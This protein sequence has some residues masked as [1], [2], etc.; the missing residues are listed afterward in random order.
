MSHLQNVP[1]HSIRKR[2]N[3]GGIVASTVYCNLSYALSPQIGCH[4]QGLE[5]LCCFFCHSTA[6]WCSHPNS[7]V[8]THVE[9]IC[10]VHACKDAYIHLDILHVYSVQENYRKRFQ[11]I[12]GILSKVCDDEWLLLS[13]FILQQTHTYVK[14]IHK[15]TLLRIFF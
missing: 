15:V 5:C 10:T 14:N 8:H 12:L 3:P 7:C 9:C 2:K 13:H 11:N 4:G 6:T 1:A